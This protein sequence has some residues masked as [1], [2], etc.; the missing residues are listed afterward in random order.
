MKTMYETHITGHPERAGIFDNLDDAIE[1]VHNDAFFNLDN[2]CGDLYITEL[3][4][5]DSGD[6]NPICP[7][8]YKWE[9]GDEHA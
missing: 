9:M 7:I 2:K 8:V 3:T 6:V 4:V 5:S 1:S